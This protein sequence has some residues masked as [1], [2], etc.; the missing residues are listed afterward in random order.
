MSLSPFRHTD[1]VHLSKSHGV[2]NRR[3]GR[4]PLVRGGLFTL[5]CLPT[6]RSSLWGLQ[7]LVCSRGVAD[8]STPPPLSPAPSLP[9]PLTRV[10]LN[11]SGEVR[12]AVQTDVG[13]VRHGPR[14]SR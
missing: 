11:S 3:K 7:A 12:E 2:P 5:G 14:A 9:S 4:P 6:R 1:T 13:F 8:V 10:N